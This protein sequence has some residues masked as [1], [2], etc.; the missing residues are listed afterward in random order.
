MICIGYVVSSVTSVAII[1]PAAYPAATQL[2]VPVL[3]VAQPSTFQ[4]LFVNAKQ[5]P[6]LVS[7]SKIAQAKI[8]PTIYVVAGGEWWGPKSSVNIQELIT[9]SCT[10]LSMKPFNWILF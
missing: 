1:Y 10:F 9:N 6:S 5:M 7:E 8:G 2:F 4:H 3:R